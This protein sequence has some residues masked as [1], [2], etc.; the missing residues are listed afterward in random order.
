VVFG[1]MYLVML[2]QLGTQFKEAELSAIQ[3][4]SSAH[5]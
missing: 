1:I 3:T 5:P 4:W 2:G